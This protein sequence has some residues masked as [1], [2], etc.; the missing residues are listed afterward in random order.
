[1]AGLVASLRIQNL[2]VHL[3]S[4][5]EIIHKLIGT[6]LIGEILALGDPTDDLSLRVDHLL[7]KPL[8]RVLVQ[9]L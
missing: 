3:L 1:M 8:F 6:V 2:T 9:V 4:I 7:I 5:Q